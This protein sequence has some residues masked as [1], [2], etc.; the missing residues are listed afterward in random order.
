MLTTNKR[1][2]KVSIVAWLY[3]RKKTVSKKIKKGVA[4]LKEIWYSNHAQ[5]KS[6]NDLWKLS[7]TSITLSQEIKYVIKL[8]YIFFGEF[9][10]GS[11]W[12]LAACL[13][14]A[15][16]TRGPN[17]INEVGLLARRSS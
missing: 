11:G 10:P 17:D 2:V 16:R 4:F 14:H 6:A 3:R 7:K 8:E 13:R 9:D 5:T 12:T 1:Y 15:S